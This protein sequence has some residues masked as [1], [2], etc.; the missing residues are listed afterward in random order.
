MT[1][2]E[3]PAPTST[4]LYAL[5][6]LRAAMMWL[7]I[8]LHVAVI[9]MSGPPLLPWRDNQT[10]PAA[11]LL[12][13]FIHAFRMPVFFILAGFFVAL[14]MEQRGPR[15]LVQ[16]RLR[17]LA[18]PFAVFWPPIFALCAVLALAFVHRMARGTWGLDIALQPRMPGAPDGLSTMHLWFLWMLLWLSLL[19]PLVRALL[20]RAAPG[21]GAALGR[22]L[23][24][25]GRTPWGI[26]LLAGVLAAVGAQYGNGMVHPSGFFLPPWTEWA[27]NG[28][29]YGFGLALYQHRQAL[30]EH[31][32]RRW[33]WYAVAGLVLFFIAGGVLRQA[34]AGTHELPMAL[35]L[36][37]SLAY[38]ATAWCW[39]FALIGLFAK[40]LR[41]P[42]PALTYLADSSYW[43]YIV[44]MPMTIGFGALMFGLPWPA[45][46]KIVL[47]IAATT[48]L[49]LISYHLLVRFGA[50]GA[51]LNGKRHTRSLQPQRPAHHAS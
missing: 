32:V 16:H 17:R 5:D 24:T 13:A 29:F 9:H 48:T 39:S 19:T 49:C 41:Q 42:S 3:A 6:N 22:W 40:H 31:Y 15:A 38:N 47:N 1:P 45:G 34:P 18:L 28:L 20:Q 4:R 50:I 27:H 37:F 33:P 12:V 35:R 2:F 46:V 10:T 26:A 51:L 11:D 44:H 21:T 36:E 43:V 14:L 25:L 23:A 7:G 8:V 30:L